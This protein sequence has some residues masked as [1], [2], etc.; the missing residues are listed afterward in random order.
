MVRQAR[1]KP[2]CYLQATILTASSI[3]HVEKFA[4]GTFSTFPT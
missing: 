1:A 3:L 4:L 2:L